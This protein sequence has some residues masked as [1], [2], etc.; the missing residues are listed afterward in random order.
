MAYICA[1]ESMTIISTKGL[2]LIQHITVVWINYD[3]QSVV[4][5]GMYCSEIV[6]EMTKSIL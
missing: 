6:M 3:L 1:I 5:Q 2:S 4:M